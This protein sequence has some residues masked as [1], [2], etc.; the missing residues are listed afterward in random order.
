MSGEA[1]KTAE[2]QECFM[3]WNDKRSK[4]KERSATETFEKIMWDALVKAV[5]V[6]EGVLVRC[7]CSRLTELHSPSLHAAY[8][9]TT[10]V[11][12]SGQA[13]SLASSE[14]HHMHLKIQALWF[15]KLLTT[16]YFKGQ[17]Q[18]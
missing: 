16:A 11:L 18:R 10:Y 12:L 13:V 9:D 3:P 8:E 5:D 14:T 6:L 15:M 7:G 4:G 17:N 2:L 1:R